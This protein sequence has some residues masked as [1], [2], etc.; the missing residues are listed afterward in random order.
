MDWIDAQCRVHRTIGPGVAERQWLIHRGNQSPDENAVSS[1]IFIDQSMARPLLFQRTMSPRTA[2]LARDSMFV[3]IVSCVATACVG[4]IADPNRAPDDDGAQR[5]RDGGIIESRGDSGHATTDGAA[6]P[7]DAS[8]DVA[9]VNPDAGT[10]PTMQ[11]QSAPPVLVPTGAYPTIPN[12]GGRVL[13][14]PALVTITFSDDT[15]R[16][17]TLQAFDRWMVT[18]SWLTTVGAEY[19]IGAGSIVADVALSDRAPDATTD[20]EIGQSLVDRINRGVLPRPTADTLYMMFF[21]AHTTITF[22]DGSTTSVS[23][24][25]FGAYHSEIHQ[26]GLDLAYSVMPQCPGAGGGAWSIDDDSISASHEFIEAATDPFPG[27]APTFALTEGTDLASLSS[28]SPWLAL[29]GEVGD[30]CAAAV[31]SY[32]EGGF[33]PTRVWSNIAARTGGDPC[34]PHVAGS[35]F[36]TTGPASDSVHVANPGDHISIAIQGYGDA[37][38]PRWQLATQIDSDFAPTVTLSATTLGPGE[39]ATVTIEV[40]TDAPSQSTA[41]IYLQSSHSDADIAVWPILIYVP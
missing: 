17:P 11:P 22:S 33:I 8:S 1:R 34:I 29:G 10:D 19:G 39:S 21:P 7:H 30:L 13:A 3:A 28:T 14:H 41:K 25:D 26:G 38:V 31:Y 6:S 4:F 16:A 5:L 36:F 40:P 23:C 32:R 27:T 15:T 12:Q 37:N 20:D 2:R 9:T 18:S 35:P 24:T